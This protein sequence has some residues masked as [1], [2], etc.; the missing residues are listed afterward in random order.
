MDKHHME[1]S[2]E[3]YMR[4]ADKIIIIAG[5]TAVGKST[6]AVKIA[7]KFGGEIV[8]AD[9]R[10]VY[11]GLNIGTGKITK[12]EM[13]GVPHHLLDVASPRRRFSVVEYQKLARQKIKDVLSMGKLPIICGGAGFYIEAVA[14]NVAL[15]D[16][17]PNE[18]LRARLRK[19]TPETLLNLLMKLDP[20]RAENIDRKNP[21]RLIRAIE[22]A[23]SLGSVPSPLPLQHSYVPCLAGRQARNVGMSKKEFNVLWIGLTL[24]PAE[25][26]R[27]IAIRLFA[28]IRKG[29]I[30]EARRLHKNGLSWKRMEELGLEY[31]HLARYL[32][33]K[34][35]KLEMTDKLQTEIWRYAKRQLTWFKR[36]RRIRW[37][38]PNQTEE[39]KT[40]VKNFL[41]KSK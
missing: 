30:Q 11:R 2:F 20:A 24:P 26:K 23:R 36:N 28:R 17:P 7:K 37:F 27:K 39:I 34:T 19:E 1:A 10:Q 8:S 16:A 6:L 21:R 32:R 41:S 13:C 3:K 25:L 29:M 4:R 38:Q 18:K 35:S 15:P 40:L 5:P 14:D 12:K 22:V 31:R 33:N 9:S